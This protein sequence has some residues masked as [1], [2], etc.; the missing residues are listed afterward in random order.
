MIL[1]PIM[2]ETLPKKSADGKSWIIGYDDDSWEP[3]LLDD[4]SSL[5]PLTRESLSLQHPASN[6]AIF[7]D[8]QPPPP[9]S[10]VTCATDQSSDSSTPCVVYM[11]QPVPS[12]L[13]VQESNPSLASPAPVAPPVLALPW[14]ETQWEASVI[15]EYKPGLVGLPNLGNTCFINA[16]L[17]CLLQNNQLIDQLSFLSSSSSPLS[18]LANTF[19]ALM[20]RIWMDSPASSSSDVP[21]LNKMMSEFKQELGARFHQFQDFRQHDCQVFLSEFIVLLL[22]CIYF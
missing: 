19:I 18:P 12:S 2:D 7:M 11:Q 9:S 1:Q 17:Q 8:K 6:L 15:E 21:P 14:V 13:S 10:T 4:I 16:G 22:N 20:K 3:I 5:D